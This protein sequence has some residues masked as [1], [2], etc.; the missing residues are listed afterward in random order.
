MFDVLSK[1][2]IRNLCYM[3]EEL[4]SNHSKQTEYI[5]HYAYLF[6]I[7]FSNKNLNFEN[8]LDFIILYDVVFIELFKDYLASNFN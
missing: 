2:D 3:K 1:N 7:F 5:I 6:N 8:I 4:M